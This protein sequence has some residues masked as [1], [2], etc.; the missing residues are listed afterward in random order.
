MTDCGQPGCGGR[1]EDGFCTVCGIAPPAGGSGATPARAASSLSVSVSSR[2]TRTGSTRSSRSSRSSRRGRLGAGLVEVPPVPYRD[3]AT[4]VMANP[5][6]VE[7]KRYCSSCNEPV[8]R[9]KDGQPG[10]TEGFCRKCGTGFSFS[11]KLVAG[12]LVAG[13]YE[14]LGCL[15]HG[16]LGWIYL[17]RDHNVNDRWVVLKGLLDTGDDDAM[18]AAIAERQF[19]AQVEHPNIVR[20]YNFVQHPDP[21][22]G[23][24]VDY[25]VMEYVGGQSLKELRAA[26]GPDGK[27]APLPLGQ[28][29]AYALEVLPALGYLHSLDLLY[30]DFKP[31][32]VIQSEEQLKLIDLGAVRRIDDE[33]SASYK[34]DGYCAPELEDDGPSVGSDLYTVARTLAVL[35]FNFDYTGVHRAS[36][37]DAAD[38]PVLARNPSFH[39][40]LRRATDRDP[41]RRFGSAQEMVEQLT[42]V[43]REVLAAED[44]QPRPGLS[45]LFSQERR[46]FGADTGDW[47][48]APRPG[49]VAA[50]LPVHQ[51]DTDD[52][53]AGFLATSAAGRPAEVIAALTASGLSTV[54]VSLRL[55]RAQIENGDQEGAAASLRAL[56]AED[57]DDWRVS[58]YLGFDALACGDAGRARAAF[59]TVYQLL[60]G[61]AAPKLALAA[62]EECAGNLADA[63]RHY[64][65]VWRT[66]HAHVS[67][68]FGLARVRLGRRDLAGAVAALESV[69]ASSSHY[70]AAR[71]A[72]VLA[73]VRD[74]TA[75]ELTVADLSSAGQQ[76]AELDLDAAQ[77]EWV[78]VDVLT[79]AQSWVQA[80]QSAPP[81]Q[82]RVLG[83]ALTDRAV[84]RGLER[85]CRALARLSDSRAERIRL[86]DLANSV[87]P[88]TLV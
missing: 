62:T 32:N 42:G 73:R 30:C 85:A 1:I 61:E 37:P 17:A 77:R 49:E 88:V 50:A 87:R 26:E 63:A 25:I 34:T 59:G 78:T 10:R 71:V 24:Q 45:P 44:G 29:I 69:P 51:V 56:S 36:L 18:A 70:V 23:G 21:R 3:P 58:W 28:A 39:Q 6:V 80:N 40:L 43:L 4:A 72:A 12:D 52:P 22:T 47:P 66:D 68:A 38:E 86:I 67:A 54:E 35:T 53:A 14:V 20:I 9:G 76:L 81:P 11:P 2:S 7:R 84:R 19:L 5:E 16:G 82:E 79:A 8:G 75:G 74:R 46:V 64:E 55:A 60:P 15:A 41:N 13:Q 33:D 48:A 65:V 57:P 83:C 27:L 31:D